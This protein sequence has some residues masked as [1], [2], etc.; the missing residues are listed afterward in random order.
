LPTR[1]DY[2][3]NVISSFYDILL[4]D[5]NADT[6]YNCVK[7]MRKGNEM[8]TTAELINEILELERRTRGITWKELAAEH[9]VNTA[10]LWKWRRGRDI[11]PAVDMLVPLAIKHCAALSEEAAQ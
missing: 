6:R 5:G 3:K 1:N 2:I 10:T 8:R 4:L 11:G 9:K 7:A